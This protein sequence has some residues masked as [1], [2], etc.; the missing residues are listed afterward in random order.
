MKIEIHPDLKTVLRLGMLR[1]SNLLPPDDDGRGIWESIDSFCEET[2]RRYKGTLT[3]Q[4]P[5]VQETRTLYRSVGLDPTKTRPS[6]EALLRRILKGRGIYRIHPLVDLINLVSVRTLF[7]VGLYDE[8]KI[9]GDTVTVQLRKT[10]WRFEGIRRGSI[11]VGKRLCVVDSKGPFGSPTADSARTSIE[12]DVKNA[13]IIFYQPK[14]AD[15]SRLEAA[16]DSTADMC[17]KH[18]SAVVRECATI[19]P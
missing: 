1:L 4:I 15:V 2:E 17:G 6:S 11:N 7:S 10:D 16:L 5:G 13:L 9:D 3:G 18:L 14:S 8:S 12:G 19:E